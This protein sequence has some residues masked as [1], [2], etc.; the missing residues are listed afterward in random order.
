MY[1]QGSNL[2]GKKN[3]QVLVLQDFN[4]PIFE[5]AADINT[6]L[7]YINKRALFNSWAVSLI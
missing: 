3:V 2:Y 4:E 5:A 6:V 7:G 1:E